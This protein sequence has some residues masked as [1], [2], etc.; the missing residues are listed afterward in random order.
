MSS[1]DRITIILTLR[2]S[3][4]EYLLS[5]GGNI[6]WQIKPVYLPFSPKEIYD[7]V[8]WGRKRINTNILLLGI[9]F[10]YKVVS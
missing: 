9:I 1:C 7:K 2:V 4:L 10:E 3:H 5:F 8:F 6:R